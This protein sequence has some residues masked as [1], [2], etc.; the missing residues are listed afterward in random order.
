MAG[1][2]QISTDVLKCPFTEGTAALRCECTNLYNLGDYT[3]DHPTEILLG[4]KEATINTYSR[5]TSISH[6][7]SRQTETYSHPIYNSYL[8]G[9]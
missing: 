6:E 7:F 3:I 1:F 8:L 9:P 4:V 5:T 2:F